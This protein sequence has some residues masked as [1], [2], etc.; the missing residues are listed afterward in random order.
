MSSGLFTRPALD[1]ASTN[2]SGAAPA[3]PAPGRAWKVLTLFG[4]RP[5]VI[6][7]APVIQQLEADGE[8]FRPSTSLPRS[9]P[10]CSIRW[11]ACSTSAVDHDLEFMEPGQT[12]NGVCS[13]VLARLD[14]VL[15]EE[16]PDAILV[17][18][19][20]T[21]AL[22]G[23]M[24]ALQSPHSRRPCR[25]RPAVGQPRQSL[26]GGDESPPHFAAGHLP[27]RGHGPEPANLLAEGVPAARIAVTGNP[28]VDSLQAIL[29]RPVRS[30]RRWKTC[31]ADRRPEAAR[32]DDPSPR[33][34]RRRDER[35]FAGAAPLRRRSCGRRPGLPG[36]S[37]SRGARPGASR[38]Q[39]WPAAFI[40]W[41]RWTISTLSGC[42]RKRG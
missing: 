4:T 15:A 6:K 39:G 25:G 12:L 38:S 23:A 11:S 13:R 41:S 37:E 1:R 32:A 3:S 19:D 14:A 8:R 29:K 5:E 20:T 9:T 17:Q 28:V 18:G 42:C 31:C 10:T 24:A 16:S 40:C 7:L 2:R 26:P 30:P 35:Q 27:F 21:T 36:A 33:E 22:A 34:L